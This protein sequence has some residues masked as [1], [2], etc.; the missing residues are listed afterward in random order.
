MNIKERMEHYH[1]AGMSISIIT[2]AEMNKLEQYGVLEAGT[3]NQVNRQSL[4]NACSISKLLT[5]MLIMVLSEKGI[6]NLDEDVNEKLSSWKIPLNDFT[7]ERPVTL[8]S[9]LSHQSGIIDSRN[10][11]AEL[12]SKEGIPSMTDLLSGKTSY[13]KESIEVNYEPG[14]EF[15]YSD[16]GYCIIQQLIEDVTGKSFEE[17]VNEFIFQPLDMQ[18]STFTMEVSEEELSSVSCGH[19][20]YGTV[21]DSKYPIYPYPA[22]AG[23]WT[24]PS[25]LSQLTIELMHSLKGRSKLG[26]SVSKAEEMITPQGSQAFTGLGVFLEGSK[27][28]C[29]ISSLGWGAGFQ[30][31]MVSYPYKGTGLIVM[32]NTDTGVHQMKGFIGEVYHAFAPGLE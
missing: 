23:L 30:S 4:F 19:N 2:N 29:E 14:S 11:F 24:T 10:S 12:N 5:S 18:N 13:C 26:L 9:L 6:V 17:I 7:K 31:L 27:R 8:R 25:D 20:K 22:A 28:E 21:I 16:A 32:T 1:I 15:R 3:A